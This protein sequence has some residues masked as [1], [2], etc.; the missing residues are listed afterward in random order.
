MNIGDLLSNSGVSWAY[1]GGGWDNAAGNINGRGWNRTGPGPICGDPD[2]APATADG[3]GANAG[4]PYCPDMSYQPHHYPF[5]YFARYAPGKPDRAHLQDE[6]DF[7]YTPHTAICRRS[8]SSSR[9]VSTT[10][11]LATPASPTAATIWST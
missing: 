11:I 8:A 9:S 7:L 2:S 3:D 4:Y 6:Q 5:A 10:N 1:Y